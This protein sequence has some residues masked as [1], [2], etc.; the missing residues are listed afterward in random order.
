MSLHQG[1][2]WWVDGEEC[3]YVA[4][5]PKW[6]R[7]FSCTVDMIIEWVKLNGWSGHF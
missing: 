5:V 7:M 4:C 1:L 3:K 6:I 2:H